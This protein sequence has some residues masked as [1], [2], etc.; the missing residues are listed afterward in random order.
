MMPKLR[1]L[2][3]NSFHYCNCM[4]VQGHWHNMNFLLP[5]SCLLTAL[6]AIK[7]YDFIIN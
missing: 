4:W 1:Q 5:Y 6:D 7:N 3:R 2:W